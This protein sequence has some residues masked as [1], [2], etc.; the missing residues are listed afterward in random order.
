M[1]EA[2]Q[3]AHGRRTGLYTSPHLVSIGERIQVDRRPLTEERVVALAEILRPHHAAIAAAT[4]LIYI[5]ALSFSALDGPDGVEVPHNLQMICVALCVLCAMLAGTAPDADPLQPLRDALEHGFSLIIFPEGTRSAQ[6]LPNPFKAG[7][8]HL[9]TEF[10]GVELIPVYIE[11]LHR[12]MPKGALLPVP[13]I[14]TVRFGAALSLGPGEDKDAFL[15]ACTELHSDE[16]DPELMFQDWEEIP[17]RYITESSIEEDLWDWLKLSPQERE[18]AS[19][20][21]E[22]VDQSADLEVAL[23]AF[24]GE[25][26]SEVDWAADFWDQTGM[27]NQLPEFAQNY[28][29][30]ESYARDCRLGGDITF[31]HKAGTVKAFRNH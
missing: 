14:C 9:A 29:D 26:D 23:E 17:S 1:I 24:D 16:N 27:V 3:R 28:I 31:V 18:I 15:E 6:P 30:Y 10:P 12:S 11:N 21:L 19:T 4:G 13:I 22:E 7:L 5:M 25:H 2:I 8:Y 20:Y